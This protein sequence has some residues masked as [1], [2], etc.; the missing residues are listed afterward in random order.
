[1]TTSSTLDHVLDFKY[2]R[3]HRRVLRSRVGPGGGAIGATPGDEACRV[4]LIVDEPLEEGRYVV[5]PRVG[6]RVH[7]AWKDP[8]ALRRFARVLLAAADQLEG[9]STSGAAPMSD[10]R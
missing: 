10:S 1:M 2:W 4:E 7:A 5:P 6:V 9:T 8:A 3:S